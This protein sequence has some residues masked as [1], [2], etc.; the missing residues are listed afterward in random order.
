M[1][2]QILIRRVRYHYISKHFKNNSEDFNLYFTFSFVDAACHVPVKIST[3]HAVYLL[4]WWILSVKFWT[5]TILDVKLEKRRQLREL[6]NY[7]LISEFLII[8]K[9]FAGEVQ[10]Y[11]KNSF[12]TRIKNENKNGFQQHQWNRIFVKHF[13]VFIEP[14][15]RKQYF[16]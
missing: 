4:A 13:S 11:V 9:S 2:E 8:S 15:S 6:F 16:C 12:I 1:G 14:H 5:S 3:T 10:I 7:L